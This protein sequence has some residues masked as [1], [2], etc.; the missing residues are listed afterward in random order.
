MRSTAVA[1]QEA[2]ALGVIAGILCLRACVD[3]PTVAILTLPCRD[4]L[5]DDTAAGVLPEVDHLRAGISLLEVVGHRHGVE[6]CHG[7]IAL[8]DTAGVL[9]RDGRAGLDLRPRELRGSATAETSFGDEVIYTALALLVAWVPVLHR[10][11]LHLG[12]LL[13]DDLDD[14]GMELVLVTLG[15]STAL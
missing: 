11:V 1:Q 9:P 15:G 10:G 14:S 2:V 13:D 4:S 5:G 12:I 8:Q 7:V 6:L 3:E